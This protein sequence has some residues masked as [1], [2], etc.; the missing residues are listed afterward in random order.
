MRILG[1]GA[2]TALRR[3]VDLVLIAL[4]A[5]RPARRHPR[6]GRPA[7]R[8]P[9]DHRSAAARWSRRSGSARRSSSA[10][11]AAGGPRASATSSRSG[12]APEQATLH[13]PDRRRRRARRRTLDPDQGRRERGPRPDAR[14]GDGRHRPG[15]A[16]RSRSP[17]TC[18]RCCRSRSGVMFV[19]GLAATLLAIAWLLESLEL[20][21]SGRR[22]AV[23]AHVAADRRA[24]PDPDPI[25]RLA[26]ALAGEPIVPARPYVDRGGRGPR[27]RRVS[28]GAVA[29]R[30]ATYVGSDPRSPQ[31]L[32]RSPGAPAARRNRWQAGRTSREPEP[33][34]DRHDPPPL[35]AVAARPRGRPWRG[36]AAPAIARPAHRQDTSTQ[37]RSR[38][39][40]SHPPTALAATG[41]TSASLT[42]TDHE[43]RLRRRLR[44]PSGDGHAAAPYSLVSDRHPAGRPTARRTR[45]RER[46]VLLRPAE[47]TSR[48]G[49]AST[50]TRRRSRYVGP[51]SRPASRAARP[52]R[53]RPTRAATATATS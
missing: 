38:P 5:R 48:T 24:A 31:Q 19:L 28:G 18:S 26:S 27:R 49:G 41:G 44:G 7:H 4:I 2:P 12:S 23:P 16:R 37:L 10:P 17:A 40:R 36:D 3:I 20:D 52:R 1:R 34:T 30:P 13:P 45:R 11:V 47:R 14:P 25:A 39:T 51:T 15:R 22:M 42:W 6:Q 33:L 50:A 43:R 32:A 21:A 29:A 9:D 53:T 8:A 46:H 35:V